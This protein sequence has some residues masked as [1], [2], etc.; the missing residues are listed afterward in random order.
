M[1]TLTQVG[2]EYKGWDDQGGGLEQR[3]GSVMNRA[4]GYISLPQSLVY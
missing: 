3:L 2:L 1:E 4:G